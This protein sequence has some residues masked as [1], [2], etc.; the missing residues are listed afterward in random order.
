[1]SD[2]NQRCCIHNSKVMH[3]SIRFLISKYNY[4]FPGTEHESRS[5]NKIGKNKLEAQT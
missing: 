3:N 4:M 5:N 2:T 1:M